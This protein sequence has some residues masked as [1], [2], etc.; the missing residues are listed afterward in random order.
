VKK[1]SRPRKTR[2]EKILAEKRKIE[3]ELAKLDELEIQLEE[4]NKKLFKRADRLLGV[5]AA[6]K[7][8][9]CTAL[10]IA[11]L[12]TIIAGLGNIVNYG[13][14]E[15]K[16]K[17]AIYEYLNSDEYAE[18]KADKIDE[19]YQEFAN[20]E[21]T[22]NEMVDK[23]NNLNS[24]EFVKENYSQ[25]FQDKLDVVEDEFKEATHTAAMLANT[26]VVG[27]LASG[28]MGLSGLG[29]E[30]RRKKVEKKDDHTRAKIFKVGVD[31]QLKEEE[32]LKY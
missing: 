2:K 19:Y 23:V 27:Y 15:E 11:I 24:L 6:L 21:K 18:I 16:E 20:G 12:S 26:A 4:E 8:T 30:K 3:R 9:A 1:T 17:Q 31:K 32:L 25:N 7:A 5:E 29:V 13:Q 10:G 14:R 28:V 22:T